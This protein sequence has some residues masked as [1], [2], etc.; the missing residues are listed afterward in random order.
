MSIFEEIFSNN[1]LELA[2]VGTLFH[3]DGKQN[4]A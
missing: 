4:H 3:I 2:S 1:S